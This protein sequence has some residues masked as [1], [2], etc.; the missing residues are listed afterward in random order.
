MKLAAI[1]ACLAILSWNAMGADLREYPTMLLKGGILDVKFVVGDNADIAD[2][3]GAVD[4]AT[5]LQFYTKQRLEG[6]ATLA[7]EV[8]DIEKS[9]LIVVGGPCA[10]PIAAKLMHFPKNCMGNFTTGK[11]MIRLFQQSRGVAIVVAGATALDTR[12]AARVLADYTQ[13]QDNFQGDYVEVTGT[14]SKDVNV[15]RVG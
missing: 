12:R 5:S 9:N 10:N 1:I 2:A 6:A 15:K 14:S 8:A 11:A 3:I 13:Y 4:I 7:S